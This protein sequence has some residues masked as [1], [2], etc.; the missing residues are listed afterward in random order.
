[1]QR[2]GARSASAHGEVLGRKTKGESVREK[3]K[4]GISIARNRTREALSGPGSRDRCHIGFI[5]FS[6]GEGEG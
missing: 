6:R 2:E 5:I 1:M 4:D 3:G